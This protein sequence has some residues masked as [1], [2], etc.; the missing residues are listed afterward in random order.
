MNSKS[1]KLFAV[2]ILS[3]LTIMTIK[4][5]KKTSNEP[6]FNDRYNDVY[7]KALAAIKKQY[8][9]AGR[10]ISVYVN[11]PASEVSYTDQ[12]GKRHIMKTS[13]I[14]TEATCGQYTCLSAPT[15][16][17]LYFTYDLKFVRWQYVCGTENQLTAVWDVSVPYNLLDQHPG[18][19]NYS[20]G[21]IRLKSGGSV[22]LTS[23]NLDQSDFTIRS[24]GTDPNCTSNTLYRV[25]Y[26]W[27]GISDSYFPGHTIEC[28][29]TVYNNCFKTNYENTVSYTVATPYSNQQDTYGL[30]CDRIDHPWTTPAGGGLTYTTVIGAYAGTC[31][32][33][34]GLTSTALHQLEYRA[35]THGSSLH[36]EDQTSTIYAGYLAASSCVTQKHTFTPLQAI[37]LCN[38]TDN[39]G[40]W[41]VRFRNRQSSGVST[42]T[43]VG[44]VGADWLSNYVTEYWNL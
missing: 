19:S 44:T 3:S 17:D 6:A 38:M 43:T 33:Q 21:N 1:L 13:G 2:I 37:E 32:P 35:V 4:S 22:V 36:W 31:S 24:L 25:E 15:G 28:S 39:S 14:Q 8:G 26:I 18:N 7:S 29:F 20:F 11:K 42:C 5:C 23:G 40:Q 34:S 30:A 27:T 9:N 12:Q 16:G 10:T 41:L